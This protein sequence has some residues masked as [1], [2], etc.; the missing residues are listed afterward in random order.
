MSPS[1]R[2]WNAW[3]FEGVDLAVPGAARAWLAG[4]L[5]GGE[6]LPA[7][8]E[9]EVTV[10]AA[11]PL[12]PLP[13]P[14]SDDAALR[15]RNA[16]GQSFPDIVA[17]RSGAIA[18]FP[19]A[20]VLPES[21]EQVVEVLRAA[22]T[23]GVAVV[24]RGGGSS[25]VGGV[26]VPA[27]ERPVIVLSLDRLAGLVALDPVSHLAR[28]RAGTYGPDLEAALAPRG[29]RL[30]H[31]PQ[32]FELSTL[33][34]WVATRSAGQ[35][36]TGVGKIEDLVAGVAVATAEGLW[37]LADQPSSAAGPELR[38]L[39]IGSEG[40]LGVITDVTVRVR[41]LPARDGGQAV[42]LRSWSEGLAVCRTLVQD[43]V[44]VEVMRL[45]DPEESSF[46]ASLLH[47]PV[48]LGRAFRAVL[49]S[50]RYRT[51]CMLLL[52][53]AG[54]RGEM[55]ETRAAARR[56]WRSRGGLSLGSRGF[57]SWRRDRFN[58]PY[59]RDVLLSAGWGIDTLETAAPWSALEALHERVRQAMGAAATAEGFPVA[60]LCHL[61]HAYPDGASLYFTFVW[62]LGR[63]CALAQWS[64]L[65][66]A[67]TEALLAGGGTL[68]HHHGVGTMHAPYLEREIGARGTA[69][70]RA[71][72]TAADPSGTLNPGVLLANAP[73]GS[74]S[75]EPGARRPG[76]GE[77]GS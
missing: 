4:R 21:P 64:A 9:A 57:R 43:G 49:A 24:I 66:R 32:S 58:H 23:A 7:V 74:R 28:F 65:K 75:P 2:R 14:T 30:G 55:R 17:L 11:R 63:D 19:D 8:A 26:T 42:L 34:G 41:E 5:G 13:A 50:R 37:R 68:T 40:R 10:P 61:S 3:G 77:G 25:V 36:S 72:A 22:R 46:A 20:V 39:V 54:E 76:R 16:C 1:T 48:L 71:A 67:A 38:R 27:G 53:W 18:A 29:F 31:E 12:P 60:V 51:G 62:P 35:R 70:L 6:P 73:F 15:L 45:S 59:L 47:L 33:G 52:G 44:P 56:R 69:L